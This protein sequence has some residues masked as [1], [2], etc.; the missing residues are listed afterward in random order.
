M[1][2]RKKKIFKIMLVIALICAP[3]LGYLLWPIRTERTGSI[4]GDPALMPGKRSYLAETKANTA[5]PHPNVIVLLADDLGKYDISLY[6]EKGPPTPNIDALAHSGVT[7]TNAYCT[8]P[9]CAPSRAGLLTGR[10]QHRFGHEFQCSGPYPINRFEILLGRAFSRNWQ[11]AWPKPYPDKQGIR[12]S[13]ITFGDVAK[14]QG[15]ATAIIGKW[16]DETPPMPKGFDYFYGFF[17]GINLFDSLDNPD[18]VY[19]HHM[20]LVDIAVRVGHRKDRMPGIWRNSEFFREKGYLTERFAE[21]S[22][23]FIEK[24]KDK[25]FCLYTSF[26]AVHEPFQVP[27]RYYERFK[28]VQDTNKRTYYAMISALDDAVGAIVQ[29]VRDEGLEEKTLFFFTSDNGGATYTG[30]TTNAPLKGGKLNQFEGGINIPFLMSWKGKLPA[31]TVYHGLTSQLDILPTIAAN[32]HAP[33]P[34]D[35]PYDGVDLVQK[36]LKQEPAHDALFWRQG[37]AKA[38][39]QGDWKLVI[40]ERTGKT[41]LYDLSTDISEKIDLSQK[42]PQKVAELKTKLKEWEKDLPPQL[43]P[44]FTYNQEWFGDDLYIFDM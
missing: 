42:N 5:E 4:Q 7:F 10:Y 23:A 1:T 43:W 35:R 2:V 27:R 33:L 3:F 37:S 44:S 6:D 36:V 14:T 29:K 30:A 19:H 8:S 38:V 9:I 11:L 25:P 32:I 17:G 41:W 21:E 13:E 15:Y 16:H 39:R 22:C 31:N 18:I 12:E 26:N 28:H 34:Q 24:N 40:S 20:N